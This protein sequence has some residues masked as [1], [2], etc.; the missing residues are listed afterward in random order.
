MWCRTFWLFRPHFSPHGRCKTRIRARK[1]EASLR[2]DQA[3]TMRLSVNLTH[4]SRCFR[5]FNS[6]QLS[7]R[8]AYGLQFMCYFPTSN[9][10]ICQA[11]SARHP[12]P[13]D[14]V[15]I[16]CYSCINI[17]CHRK[18]T[19]PKISGDSGPWMAWPDVAGPTTAN[20][21]CGWRGSPKWCPNTSDEHGKALDNI[22]I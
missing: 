18:F 10:N 8:K 13:W 2:N 7:V 17:Q 6:S 20:G 14:G 12:D 16:Q 19:L 15:G 4:A 9:N 11:H 21:L 5:D 22:Y 3:W 1:E